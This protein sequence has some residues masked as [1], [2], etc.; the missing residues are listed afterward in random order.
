M[1]T[2]WSLIK[3]TDLKLNGVKSKKNNLNFMEFN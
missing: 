1:K 2:S 3:E